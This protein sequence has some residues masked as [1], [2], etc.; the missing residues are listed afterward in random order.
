MKIFKYFFDYHDKKIRS[1]IV[2][3]YVGPSILHTGEWLLVDDKLQ[4]VREYSNQIAVK[5]SH[6]VPNDMSFN[7]F[8]NLI[9]DYINI[10][11]DIMGYI[12]L[13]IDDKIYNI[14]YCQQVNDDIGIIHLLD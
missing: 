4:Y 7:T 12:K 8:N 1:L 3:T 10:V 6:G 13:D 11:P 9:N 5:I 2:D 14:K